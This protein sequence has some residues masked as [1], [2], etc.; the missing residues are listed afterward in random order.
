MTELLIVDD[1]TS[2]LDGLTLTVPWDRLG[3]GP[4][5]RASSGAEALE[6]L[7][8]NAV[9]IVITDIRM[10]GM[11]GLEL[12]REIR[13]RWP[14]V[15]CIIL[16][17]HGEFEYAKEALR[18]DAEDFLLKPVRVEHLLESVG[19]VQSRLENERAA[20]RAVR[21]T[22]EALRENL[23]LLRDDLLRALTAGRAE[24]GE[25][26]ARKLGLLG[27]PF[28]EGPCSLLLV[29]IDESF[30]SGFGSG[31]G[32]LFEFAVVNVAEELFGPL[33]RIWSAKHEPDC[34]V[35]LL[36][37]KR[38]EMDPE[39]QNAATDRLGRRLHQTVKTDLKGTISVLAGHAGRFPE[40]IR[41]LYETLTAWMNQRVGN[42]IGFFAS[43]DG[44]APG[45]AGGRAAGTLEEPYRIP[46]LLHLL[47]SGR[48][49]DAESKLDAIFR[50]LTGTFAGSRE[51]LTEAHY[52]I[53]SAFTRISHQQGRL[54]HSLSDA[55]GEPAGRTEPFRSVRQ[56]REWAFATLHALRTE[57]GREPGGTRAAVVARVRRFAHENLADA[58]LQNIADHV[59]LHPV[60]VCKVYKAETGETLSDYLYRLRMEK[61]AF[62]LK[63]DSDKIYRI[64]EKI[65]YE[66]TYFTKVFKKHF[67]VTP[68][69]YRDR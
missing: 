33:F 52:H 36:Q 17:G 21:Q 11:S 18:A 54:L 46:H 42:E 65:G 5:H 51:H 2:V 9:D 10:P 37:P 19:R 69:E 48:W 24:L 8:R 59:H 22:S 6:L 20:S 50:E 55:G 15:K 68:Q 29:R 56:M 47:E 49:E 40:D 28:A 62:L 39:E 38:E 32:E 1:E 34:L 58:S 4:I 30:G 45:W 53:S 43:P 35:F 63:N 16:S 64:A 61:A 44:S 3:V 23:P 14:D 13:S 7:E 66:N 60:Y 31:D 12:I 27:L 57:T 26:L 41:R 25:R 67:G